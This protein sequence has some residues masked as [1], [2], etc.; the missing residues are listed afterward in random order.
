[1]NTCTECGEE[2]KVVEETFDYAG[3]HCTHGQ[4]GTHHTGIFVSECCLAEFDEGEES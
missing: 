2:C 4:A 3:T 1:M